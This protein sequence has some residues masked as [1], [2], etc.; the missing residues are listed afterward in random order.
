M[1]KKLISV[2]HAPYYAV[3]FTSLRTGVN[4]DYQETNELLFAEAEKVNG[5]LGQEAV[6]DGLGIAVSYWKTLEAVNEW[7]NNVHHKM[8]KARGISEWYTEY[9]IRICKVEHENHFVKE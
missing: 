9:N 8:A 1:T 4:T 7:R 5:F 2:G 3:I 6:R